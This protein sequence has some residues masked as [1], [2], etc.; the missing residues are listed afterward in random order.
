MPSPGTVRP[1][2]RTARTREAVRA[3]TLAELA[4]KGFDGLTVEGVAARSGVHKT[5][6]YR[7]W[8][9][10]A[11]LAADALDLAGGEPWPVPDTGTL[12]ADLRELARL[13]ATAFAD[14]EL[15]P[16]SRAFISAAIQEPTAAQAL[17]AFFTARHQQASVVVV[18]AIERGELPSC[19]DAVEVVR[20]AVAPIYYRL[21]ISGE[22]VDLDI[23]DRSAAAAHAAAVSG[24]F[25][26]R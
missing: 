7:R 15:G 2:G 5:T 13:V 18:R 24:V 4:E 23:A 26:R 1:G 20:T 10:R 11:G 9:N 19:T 22:P 16:V 25:R 3:A 12:S 6:I 17:H 14:P 8:R 21:F